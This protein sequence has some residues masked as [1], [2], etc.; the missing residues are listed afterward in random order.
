MRERLLLAHSFRGSGS[1]M[2]CLVAFGSA[3]RQNI[4]VSVCE[5]NL[6][7]GPGSKGEKGVEII[8]YPSR[9]LSQ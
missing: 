2:G 7:S 5:Q 9:L 1:W 6:N 4:M 3:E 8:L